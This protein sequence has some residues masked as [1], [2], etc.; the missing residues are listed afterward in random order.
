VNDQERIKSLT[1]TLLKVRQEDTAQ[2]DQSFQNPRNS[3]PDTSAISTQMA[4]N[5][6]K[7]SRSIANVGNTGYQKGEQLQT[8]G[9][10]VKSPVAPVR[11][12]GENAR[13]PRFNRLVRGGS[14]VSREKPQ[15]V[16]ESEKIQH[17]NTGK[18]GHHRKANSSQLPQGLRTDNN[19]E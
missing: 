18:P 6:S 8:V 2:M 7:R 16:P 1:Q 10:R 11:G 13:S 4:T 14:P 15:A 12:V 17:S 9:E 3:S 5:I 19:K